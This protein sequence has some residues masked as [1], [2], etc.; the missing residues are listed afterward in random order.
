MMHRGTPTPAGVLA[1]V[2]MSCTALLPV[3]A[4]EVRPPRLTHEAGWR[5]TFTD[6]FSGA[7][8]S[9]CWQNSYSGPV[10]TLEANKEAEWY[11][12]TGDG[13]GFNATPVEHGKLVLQAVSKPA[14]VTLPKK[15][16]YL[17]GM[18]MS[19]GCFAQTYGYFEIR[20]KV[21]RGKGLWPAFWLLPTSHKWPP[22]IDVFE[23]FGAPNSRKEGGV[24]WVHTGT[25]H[26]GEKSFTDWHHVP[27]DQYA[28]FHRYGLLWGPDVMAIFVDGRKI[29]SQ[30]TPLQYHQPMYLIVNLAV[31][32]EW[33]ELPDQNTKFPA[34]M[35]VDYVRA[36]Q[37]KPWEAKPASLPQP[38]S[39][40][41]P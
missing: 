5:R 24:G 6:N 26:A 31:G 41:K 29:V 33:P 14:G 28:S 3:R 35:Y 4:S 32:G 21:P 38:S 1:I 23:M 20:A 19:D 12:Y 36:W 8:L 13:T 27:I 25:V 16:D 17:S 39:E 11:A 2:M 18:V 40:V 9:H 30:R 7:S 37:Y 10:H 15:L 22:E 34:R